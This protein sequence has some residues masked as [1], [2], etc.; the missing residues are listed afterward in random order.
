LQTQQIQQQTLVLRA[1]LKRTEDQIY[2][3]TN[4]VNRSFEQGSERPVIPATIHA[5]TIPNLQRH[6]EAVRNALETLKQQIADLES[7]DRTS[8]A[9]ELEEELKM[10]YCE[11]QRL[12]R[13][14]QD[15]RAVIAAY[16]KDL[17]DAESRA[18]SEHVLNQRA[19]LRSL[20]SENASLRSK[21]NA[22]QLKTQK[23]QIEMQIGECQR[24]NRPIQEVINQAEV[25][26]AEMNRE[27]AILRTEL[28][29]EARAHRERV[30]GLLAIINAM[31]Q[32]IAQRLNQ[33][34]PP[35]ISA[36]VQ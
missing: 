35:D 10:T 3:R 7:D 36:T 6:I 16:A 27:L 24:Q 9:Q 29:Q 20:Q 12:L 14:L 21:S 28:E 8:T 17:R 25:E 26:Q 15:K 31:R 23:M 30:A 1:Q 2:T 32:K 18:S 34:P 4:T 13:G 19:Q 11:H 5:I 22:Y 33:E